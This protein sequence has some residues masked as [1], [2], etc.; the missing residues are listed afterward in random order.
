MPSREER[1]AQNEVRFREINEAAQPQ[2][3]RHGAGRFVCECAD[4][5]CLAWLDIPLDAYE[6][7]RANPRLFV[8]TPGH[9]LPD[10]ESVV[11]RADG[12]FVVAKPDEVA[13]VV[14]G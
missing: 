13:H 10:V 11:E 3:E 8:V 1:L 6:A 12:W 5:G 14:E 4:R 2:R 9:E 7:V